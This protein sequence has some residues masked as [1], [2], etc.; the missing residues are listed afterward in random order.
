MLNDSIPT[1]ATH[2]TQPISFETLVWRYPALDAI[3][4]AAE[5]THDWRRLACLRSD[6]R[7][8]N[9]ADAE[10]AVALGLLSCY[11]PVMIPVKRERRAA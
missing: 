6:I 10:E 8:L 1:P 5:R 11:A 3:F 2:S 7:A 9:M 4:A